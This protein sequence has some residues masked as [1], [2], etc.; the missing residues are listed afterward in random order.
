MTF[1]SDEKNFLEINTTVL[2][3]VEQALERY[4]DHNDPG[5]LTG[6]L[7]DFVRDWRKLSLEETYR[8]YEKEKPSK[9]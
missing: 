8:L 2:F 9:G 5:E 6:S 4:I 1:S 7:R 3:A